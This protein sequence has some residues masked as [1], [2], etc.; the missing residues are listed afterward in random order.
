MWKG[1]T[2]E[3]RKEHAI[4]DQEVRKWIDDYAISGGRIFC[5]NGCQECCNLAVNCTFT[6]AL[7]V[8]ETLPEAKV[9]RVSEH[10][11]LLRK[12]IP[13][14][15]DLRSYLRLHRQKI[16]FCPF[17]DDKGSCSVYNER[18]FSCRSLLATKES[19]W[20]GADFSLLSSTEKRDF[21]ESLDP[22]VVSFPM[23]YVAPAQEWG[24]EFEGRAARLMAER[25]G[26]SLYGNLPFLVF[27]EREL[28]LSGAMLEGYEATAL[29]LEQTGLLLPFLLTFDDH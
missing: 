2:R 24:Q 1:L 26:F 18:P 5:N 3:V 17:L 21:V 16:G 29:L 8:A 25:I 15:T 27:L 20:C 11:A 13:E 22:S 7:C 4:F 12:H 10:A 14:A 28:H 9:V 19:R 23:H 6:E